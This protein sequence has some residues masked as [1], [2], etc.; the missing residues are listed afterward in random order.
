MDVMI[1]VMCTQSDGTPELGVV[2]VALNPSTRGEGG[3]QSSVNP[4]TVS[5]TVKFYH[6]NKTNKTPG[7]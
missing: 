4:R 2:T 5:Y 6:K 1:T 3:R 7:F